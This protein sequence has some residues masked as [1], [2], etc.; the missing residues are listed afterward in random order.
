MATASHP[1]LLDQRLDALDRVLLGLLPRTERLALV[2][3]VET[4]ISEL[5]DAIPAVEP[6][7]DV[8]GESCTPD[9]VARSGAPRGARRRSRIALSSG[10]LGIVALVML[11]LMPITYVIVSMIGESLGEFVAYALLIM[12]VLTVAVGGLAALAMGIMGL[13]RLARRKGRVV[14][15]GWAITGLCTSPLPTLVGG[16][17]AI[18]FLGLSFGSDGATYNSQPTMVSSSPYAPNSITPVELPMPVSPAG[19]PCY[20]SNDYCAP[21]DGIACP[22]S[23]QPLPRTATRPGAKPVWPNAPA[24]APAPIGPQSAP[25]ATPLSAPVSPAR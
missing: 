16:L 21:C 7:A 11:F 5:A 18:T 4:R 17:L 25:D 6:G 22:T 8:A 23:P 10:I 1:D 14:G 13:V 20:P 2:A 9:L 3:Q 15:Y 19:Y 12:H 24:A